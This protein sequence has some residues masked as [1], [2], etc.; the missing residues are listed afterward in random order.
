[1][2]QNVEEK[3][4]KTLQCL[5]N[6]EFQN[7]K[8]YLKKPVLEFQGIP[9][10]HLEEA[11]RCKTVDLMVQNYQGLGALRVTLEV[12]GK[13]QR[14][15][16]AKDL[17]EDNKHFKGKERFSSSGASETHIYGNIQESQNTLLRN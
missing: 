8:W 4:L 10:A 14:N 6:E 11:H 13:I 1:M 9:V 2:E 16:L 5:T 15:D 7:L 17:S 3:L 12:L